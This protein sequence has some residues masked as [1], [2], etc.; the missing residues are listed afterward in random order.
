MSFLSE[1]S[2]VLSHAQSHHG[3]SDNESNN[4][5][6]NGALSMLDSRKDEFSDSGAYEVDEE[7][8]MRAHDSLSSG[9]GEGG[10]GSEDVGTGAAMQ[11][12]KMFTSGGEGEGGGMDKNRFIGMAMAQAGKVWDE[13]NES[14]S[15]VCIRFCFCFVFPGLE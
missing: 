15:V 6:F 12:L 1:F 2:S 7:R 13:K 11:A 14:G 5:L 4:A 3:S 9:G 10:H 8:Y